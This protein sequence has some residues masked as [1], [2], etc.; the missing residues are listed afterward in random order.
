MQQYFS[1]PPSHSTAGIVV[2]FHVRSVKD[3]DA[4][5]EAGRPVFRD[6]EY[7]E[8]RVVGDNNNVV[9]REI[10]A[11]DK[12][13]FGRQYE[14]WKR[15]REQTAPGIP[16]TEWP[17]LTPSQVDTLRYNHVSTVELLAEISDQN[18]SKLGMGYD[19]LRQRARDYLAAA[20]GLAPI[21]ALRKENEELKS[22]IAMQMKAVEEMRRELDAMKA[23][24]EDIRTSRK[25]RQQS[26]T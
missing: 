18:L 12:Q 23:S 21:D 19:A 2:R 1:P 15:G 4:S 25:P 24:S 3:E 17:G 10:R 8:K 9:D 11:E 16:L 5:R 7:I 6:A 13:Q 20:A 14:D 22:H 26:M